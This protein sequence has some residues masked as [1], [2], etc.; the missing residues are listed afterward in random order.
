MLNTSQIFALLFL[1]LGPFKILGPFIKIT[2]NA[3][4]ALTRKIAVRAILFS[5]A[6]LL[7]A[8]FLGENIL[9]R[10]GIPIPIL[11]L[12]GGIILFLVALLNII[13]QFQ[14]TVADE[15]SEKL[16]PLSVAINPLAFPT[17]VTPHGIAAVIVF[18]ALSPDL[19]SK[20]TVVAIVTG[21]M[22]LNLMVMFF[23]RRIFN[24]LSLVL[25]LLG[26]VLGVVQVAL[27]AKIIYNSLIKLL[28]L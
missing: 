22:L 26:A 15:E 16:P 5:I 23:A 27:G 28:A 21:I 7:L 20:L 17:I 4:T 2:K 18:I 12:S 13:H 3:D 9:S 14:P 24:T 11:S 19:N 1:M 25:V 10:Y 6:A 8:A